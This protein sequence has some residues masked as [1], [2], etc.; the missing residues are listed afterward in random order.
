MHVKNLLEP[1][2][3][4]I[5]KHARNGMTKAVKDAEANL[6]VIVGLAEAKLM[7]DN[8]KRKNVCP[9]E[10]L[11]LS[12]TNLAVGEITFPDKDLHSLNLPVPLLKSP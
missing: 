1:E 2:E 6:F 3:D 8:C 4:V 7:K 11:N 12:L 9:T 5:R 10:N